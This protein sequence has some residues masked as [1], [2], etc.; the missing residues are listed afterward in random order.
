MIQAWILA[1]LLILPA[2]VEAAIGSVSTLAGS[3]AQLEREKKTSALEK[4]SQIKSNDLVVVG[5]NTNTEI[6]FIDNTNVKITANSRL[7]IDDFVFDPNRSD[8]GKMGLKVALGSVRYASGQIAKAN[9]QRV[10]IKTPTATIAVR[11]TDFSM[12]VDETG[13]S[14]I[15]LLPSCVTE[16]QL[17]KFEILGNCITGEIIVS[18][19]AGS[20]RMNQPFTATVVVDAA[21]PPTPPVPVPMDISQV[22]SNDVMLSVPQNLLAAVA[23]AENKKKEIKAETEEEKSAQRDSSTP[24][25]IQQQEEE[26][27][28]IAGTQ[29]NN[30]APNLPVVSST[31]DA[32]PDC[33]PFTECGNIQ[34]RNYYY[35]EDEMKGNVISIR[36]GEKTDNTTYNISVNSNDIQTRV[37]GNGSS[38]ITVRQWNK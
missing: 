23:A 1:A 9:P 22:T 35:K 14:I 38:V 13:K 25:D 11:G 36:T 12:T 24:T 37:V 10:S 28:L 16:D 30:P 5:S 17:R 8:A 27:V 18:T 32:E 20:V 26:T 4:S 34:G 7:L 33:Y 2:S 3:H 31:A 29:E 21:Q 6:K 19:A 15:V